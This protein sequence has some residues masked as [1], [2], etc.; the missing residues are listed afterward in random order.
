MRALTHHAS[1]ITRHLPPLPA[2]PPPSP[3]RPHIANQ[4]MTHS[5][6]LSNFIKNQSNIQCRRRA[7]PRVSVHALLARHSLCSIDACRG[8]AA[9]WTAFRVGAARDREPEREEGVSARTHVTRV[10]SHVTR[11]MSHVT[12][13]TPAPASCHREW[14]LLRILTGVSS[15]ACARR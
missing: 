15:A 8:I 9:A 12:R 6:C 4:N 2:S 3:P 7:S 5:T 11:V 10:M 1:R 13:L 14:E